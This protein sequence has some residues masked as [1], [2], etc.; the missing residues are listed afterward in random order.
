[1]LHSTPAVSIGMPVYNGEK[2]IC[3]A[4][5]SLLA[6]TYRN[7]E[8]IISDNASNDKTECICR[9]Y[10]SRDKRIHYIRQQQN[11][12]AA[13]NFQFVLDQATGEYFMWAA[14]DDCWKPH[15]INQAVLAMNEES[16]GFA[17]P[18]FTLKS[19]YLGIFTKV[20]KHIFKEIENNDKNKRILSFANLHHCSHKC[21]LVYSLFKIEILRKSIA[22]QDISN[23][24][25][26]SM[27]LLGETRGI[28]IEGFGFSKRYPLL[29]PGFGNKLLKI[30]K[31]NENENE[32]KNAKNN[33][34]NIAK[35]IFPELTNPL[36][37]IC[38]AYQA[39][40]YHKKYE[41][42]KDFLQLPSSQGKS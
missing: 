40:Q 19:I 20:P 28:L 26:L 25:L 14:Y 23:D 17:F 36:D 31:K 7:F 16:I 41:I 32:F 30:F 4:L 10:A 13:T 33:A 12:G 24:G 21:N 37:K 9:E 3:N 15:Y 18:T 35:K 29:W 38:A 8:L 5:D 42:I 27:V 39:N 2:F 34:F 1:M 6:Q 22:T 11:K